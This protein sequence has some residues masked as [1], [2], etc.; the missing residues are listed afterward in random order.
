VLTK[1]DGQPYRISIAD[2]LIPELVPIARE[3]QKTC[4]N[5]QFWHD[6]NYEQY[7]DGHWYFNGQV[8]N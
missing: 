7:H 8:A 3:A 6:G 4:V 5:P 2:R 1:V